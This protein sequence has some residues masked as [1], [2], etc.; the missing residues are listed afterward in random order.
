MLLLPEGQRAKLGAPPK[1][2]ALSEIREHWL[3]K[4][5]R[6]FFVPEGL[7]AETKKNNSSFCFCEK[8]PLCS[9]ISGIQH[10]H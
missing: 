3:E 2:N 5:L 9:V 7:N 10:V 8:L 4:E 1:S 6:F